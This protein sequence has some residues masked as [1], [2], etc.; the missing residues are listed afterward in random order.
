MDRESQLIC[1]FLMNTLPGQALLI[2]VAL[3][4]GSPK[5]ERVGNPDDSQATGV[6]RDLHGSSVLRGNAAAGHRAKDAN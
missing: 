4:G 5:P 3:A 2:A 6:I 1:S